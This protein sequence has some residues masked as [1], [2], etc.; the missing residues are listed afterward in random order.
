MKKWGFFT[1]AVARYPNN[2]PLH[3][4][5]G[6]AHLCSG[7]Y[8]SSLIA[9]QQAAKLNP[10]PPAWILR[11]ISALKNHIVDL[12]GVSLNVPSDVVN[13]NVL[14]F[15]IEGGY[16]SKEL[17]LLAKCIN[18]GERILELGAGLGFLACYVTKSFPDTPYI[19]VEANPSLVPLIRDNFK[20]N[21]CHANLIHGVAGNSTGSSPFNLAK[22][23]WASSV[24]DLSMEYETVTV[25]S[26][27]T[28]ALIDKLD[29][30]M[31]VIDIE[32]GDL[33]LLPL[34]NLSNIQKVIVELHPGVYGHDGG[35]KVVKYL[36]DIG[37]SID[38]QLSGSQVFLFFR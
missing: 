24:C 1:G 22:D 18:E 8:Q 21:N 13:A 32:G 6:M 3:A 25:P 28:N 15:L 31:M 5:L 4:Q 33:E 7:D 29:P 17:N 16:E 38:V 37:F 2:S 9:F 27:D 36:L 11:G 12:Q 35:T 14:R 34:L 20:L 30:T 26:I 10:A 23:F 19:A